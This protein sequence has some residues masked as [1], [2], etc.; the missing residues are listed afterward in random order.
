MLL[1]KYISKYDEMET[2]IHTYL[3][4]SDEVKKFFIQKHFVEAK[5]TRFVSFAGSVQKESTK[6]LNNNDFKQQKSNT[7]LRLS[8]EQRWFLVKSL[9]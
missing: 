3:E 5:N 6:E 1:P 7:F 8:K 2:P 4:F 9:K